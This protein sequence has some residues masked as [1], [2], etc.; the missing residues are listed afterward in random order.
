MTAAQPPSVLRLIRA[1]AKKNGA[2]LFE[3]GKHFRFS[4]TND[5]AFDYCGLGETLRDVWVRLG[6]E[7]QVANAS[8]AVASCQAL[9]HYNIAIG[10]KAL[11]IG[12]GNCRW[13]AR[14]EI[15]SKKPTIILDGAQNGASMQ[16][17]R[18]TIKQRFGRSALWLI[19]GIAKDKELADTCRAAS[20]ISENIIVTKANNPRA[21]SPQRLA[22]YFPSTSRMFMSESVREALG[23]AASK[24]NSNGLIVITGSL[25]VCAEARAI[26]RTRQ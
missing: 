1:V 6:G 5:N 8:L 23:L 14:F 19:F 13:P 7:H 12:L 20:L 4:I 11:R 18:K 2:R 10:E 25:Y 26:V 9:R 21:M 22:K 24:T 16:A 15:I 3:A 17:L